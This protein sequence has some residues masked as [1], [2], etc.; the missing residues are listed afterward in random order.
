MSIQPIN[1]QTAAAAATAPGRVASTNQGG[2][3][4][5]EQSAAVSLST[6]VTDLQSN[7]HD[8]DMVKVATLREALAS[9]SLEI[10][11]D[12][13]AQGLINDALALLGRSK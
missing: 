7:D 2:A 5:P 4:T 1:S 8:V 9:G 11:P 10:H 6:S 12:R 3:D 13:I